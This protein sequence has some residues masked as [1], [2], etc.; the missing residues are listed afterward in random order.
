MGLNIAQAASMVAAHPIIGIDIYKHKKDMGKKFGLTH[1][2]TTNSSNQNNEIY[3]II[4]TKG[5]DIASSATVVIGT[6]GSFFD[7]T[8]TTGIS[9]Q[10]TVDAGRVF[11]LQFDGALTFTHHATDLILPG[12]ASITTAAGDIAVMYE[13]ASADWRCVSYTKASGAS[14]VAGG[15][16]QGTE[17]ATTTGTSITFSR[18]IIF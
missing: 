8:G 17:Q 15:F 13:Y 18:F 3:N 6:D 2:I 1:G 9:T 12:G 10:F 5:A 11:T 16:T 7:I 14:V 4:G